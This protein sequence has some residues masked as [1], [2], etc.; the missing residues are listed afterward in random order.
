M[1]FDGVPF[2][3]VTVTRLAGLQVPVIVGRGFV[4]M[5]GT[6]IVMN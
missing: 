1:L 2:V 4:E 3:I 6:R 5:A